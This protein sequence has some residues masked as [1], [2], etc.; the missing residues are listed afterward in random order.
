MTRQTAMMPIEIT[1]VLSATCSAARLQRFRSP[2]PR[3]WEHRI[4]PPVASAAAAALPVPG[5]KVL[6]AQD[7]SAGRERGKNLNEQHIDRIHERDRRDRGAPDARHHHCVH[8]THERIQQLLQHQRHKKSP[9]RPPVKKEAV[10][11]DL[12]RV[13][14]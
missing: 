1:A 14:E 10:P 5:A 11:G 12:C 8:H 6:G 4:V 9:E 13:I 7:R 2:D 3:Y